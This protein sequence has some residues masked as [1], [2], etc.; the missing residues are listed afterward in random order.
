MNKVFKLRKI[1]QSDSKVLL[2]WRNDQRRNF[3]NSDEITL[4]QHKE[5]I[6]E[7]P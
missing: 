5:Y 6:K 4:S 1:I 3:F 2:K 7:T